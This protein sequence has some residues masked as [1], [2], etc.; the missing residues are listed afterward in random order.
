MP[1]TSRW[2]TYRKL[3]AADPRCTAVSS[4][5]ARIGAYE[6]RLEQEKVLF[7]NPFSR[8]IDCLFDGRAYEAAAL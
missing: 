4:E 7:C 2:A 3:L 1:A 5:D 8:L 6:E